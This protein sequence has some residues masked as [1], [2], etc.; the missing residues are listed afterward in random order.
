MDPE[1]SDANVLW[2]DD[3]GFFYDVLS[4]PDGRSATD[5]S[6]FARRPAAAGRVRSC[7]AGEATKLPE[8]MDRVAG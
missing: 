8:F 4:L 6:A 1:G 2:D 7:S 3:D 5:E